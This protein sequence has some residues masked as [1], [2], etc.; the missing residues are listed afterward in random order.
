[1]NDFANTYTSWTDQQLL[2]AYQQREDY[3][4]EAVKA[5]YAALNKRGLGGAIEN[6]EKNE[7]VKRLIR[8]SE[9]KK[10]YEEKVFDAV[11]TDAAYAMK[12][13]QADGS[14]WTGILRK[15][16]PFGLTGGGSLVALGIVSLSFLIIRLFS[17]ELFGYDLFV[18]AGSCVIFG[19]WGIY[20][21]MRNKISCR[22]YENKDRKIL[23]EIADKNSPAVI[24]FPF[25]YKFYTGKMLLRNVT[26]STMGSVSSKVK[27]PMVYL[28]I[29]RSAG[30]NIIIV[31]NLSVYGILPADTEQ[32]DDNMQQIAGSKVY[33]G[34]HLREL[35]KILN[36]LR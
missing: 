31:E 7:Q 21:M 35:R 25:E 15:G 19:G 8:Q 34:R 5:I 3:Q 1:M 12:H 10:S 29:K 26:V 9:D 28:F 17:Y 27:I 33:T 2:E 22:L 14:Y 6:I 32:I 18:F 30:S 36:G 16:S 11:I 23:F 13:K 24:P 20:L 4:E